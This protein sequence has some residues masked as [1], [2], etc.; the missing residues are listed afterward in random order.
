MRGEAA[1]RSFREVALV[2]H[3]LTRIH[4]G[5]MNLISVLRGLAAGGESAGFDW[6]EWCG[7]YW[8]GEG[9]LP[10]EPSDE[11]MH[12][13]LWELLIDGQVLRTDE[14]QATMSD[15]ADLLK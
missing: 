8:R 2:P 5:N 7:V 4:R 14:A 6:D 10:V 13:P 11:G 12:E 1:S 15:V 9:V 3:P